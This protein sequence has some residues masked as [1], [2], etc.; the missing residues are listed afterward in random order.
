M[1]SLNGEPEWTLPSFSGRT[2][3]WASMLIAAM[4]PLIHTIPHTRDGT[5]H[6]H[7]HDVS[8]IQ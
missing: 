2:S 4:E 3:K 6:N 5:H 1:R 8:D 7:A